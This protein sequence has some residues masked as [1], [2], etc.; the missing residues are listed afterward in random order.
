MTRLR[1]ATAFTP[2][3]ARS[4]R[5]MDGL[6]RFCNIPFQLLV[7]GQDM[8]D[9]GMPRSIVQAGHFLP[10][11]KDCDTVI[12][13]DADILMHRSLDA[14]EIAFLCS[15]KE[16]QVAA[17]YNHHGEELFAEEAAALAPRHALEGYEDVRVFNTGFVVARVDTYRQMF[18][19]FEEL[20][21]EF[22]ACFQ[23]YAKIQLCICAAVARCG[24]EWVPVPGHLCS[25]GHFGPAPGVDPNA[26]PPTHNGRVICLDHRASG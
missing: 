12:F 2:D 23:H 13:T 25:Q 18:R 7:V 16:G 15:I 3:Y 8:P 1:L 20:W 26:N 24:F 19:E 4:A 9:F 11:L 17:C 21:P 5:Y 10:Y 14:D 6:N 22:D